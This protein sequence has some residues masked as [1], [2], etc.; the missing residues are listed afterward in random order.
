MAS[1]SN[2][3]LF[4]KHFKIA[5][6][7]LAKAGLID[8]FL[9]VDTRLFIDPILLDKC[10]NKI[11]SEEAY[12]AFRKYFENVIRLLA[13]SKK[14][15]DAAWRAA[16]NQFNLRE[17]PANGLG[18][19]RSDRPGTSRPEEIR[20]AIL[21]TA[22]EIIEL[23]SQD[24]EMISLMGFFE[25]KVGADT[26]S[27]LTSRIIEPQL[28]KL[29]HEFCTPLGITLKTSDT[30]PDIPLPH[31]TSANGK[32]R[33][34]VL[35]PADIV[36]E[37]PMANDWSDIEAAIDA[38]AA[39]RARVNHL[40][41]GITRPKVDDLK[42]AV[43]E[44]ALQSKELFE[45][46]IAAIKENAAY[47]DPNSDVLGYYTLRRILGSKEYEL[48]SNK[49]YEIEKGID[50]IHRV[51]NDT[52]D[53]FKHHVEKGN[54]WEALWIDDKP[55]KERAAQL[56]YFAI[57][58]CF[59][60]ANDIDISPEANMGGGPIDFK[61]S[62]GYSARVLVEMKRS[63]GTVVHGYKEQ[64]EIYKDASRTSHGVFVVLDYGDL[65]KKLTTIQAIRDALL[66][67][68]E[69]ASEIVVIDAT[70]KISAS[71]RK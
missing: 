2:P 62:K 59:C 7:E 52:M 41:A 24:P 38:N 4:S 51:V 19:G 61:Y 65:G 32:E 8:P 34:I 55:K 35:V 40:L 20:N 30:S 69:P 3:L 58:D 11:I 44:A 9:T 21:R 28:A 56:I 46:F 14:E 13:I 42:K 66:E 64:L 43:R 6:D 48:K 27:D 45:A 25:E 50:E 22:K 26:I 37:L 31:Y 49:K 39:I 70:Q 12:K 60:K 15:G 10:S 68:G 54:L 71:K 57:T 33:A 5:P 18:Y 1:F 23:G 63:S 16:Q 17:A 53:M 67:S 47:Y 29:T 36:R